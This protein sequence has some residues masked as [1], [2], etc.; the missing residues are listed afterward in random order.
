MWKHPGNRWRCR[1]VK[2]GGGGGM[3]GGV[4]RINLNEGCVKYPHRNLLFSNPLK[5]TFKKILK[6]D[7]LC[8]W[9]T[10]LLWPRVTKQNSQSWVCFF[11]AVWFRRPGR[12]APFHSFWL[13]A[14]IKWQLPLPGVTMPDFGCKNQ[15]NKTDRAGSC[16][17]VGLKLLCRLLEEKS[18][19]FSYATVN[20]AIYSLNLPRKMYP[21]VQKQNDFY[22]VSQLLSGW[23][24]GQYY[25]GNSMPGAENLSKNPWLRNLK[26]KIWKLVFY[27][28]NC[29]AK[30]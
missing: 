29:V 16:L 7:T 14:R 17:P 15:R 1:V 10:L 23:I 24:W 5:N 18:Q 11:W 9:I 27:N 20:S 21:L 8:D 13:T 3:G 22:G 26:K 28:I 2:W 19:Q 12:K 30:I 25:S 4:E 6:W